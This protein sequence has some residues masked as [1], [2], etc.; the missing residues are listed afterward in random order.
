M[1]EIFAEILGKRAAEV[2]RRTSDLPPTGVAVTGRI[3]AP[4]ECELAV[5]IDFRGTMT[6]GAPVSGYVLCGSV[7]HEQSRPLLA[8]MAR[9]FGLSG[10]WADSAQGA[11]DILGEFLN[12]IVGLAAADWG[13]H[14]FEMDFSTPENVSGRPPSAFGPDD[15]PF[16]IVVTTE[17]GAEVHLLAVFSG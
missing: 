9:H 11:A 17:G 5:R 8:A 3:A 13:E 4:P 10:S 14:G 6:G 16:H 15:H 7:R 1:N 2:V 12:I